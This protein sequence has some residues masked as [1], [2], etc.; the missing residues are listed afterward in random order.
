MATLCYRGISYGTMPVCLSVCLSV[1]SQCCIETN[2]RIEFFGVETITPSAYHPILCWKEI[3]VFSKIRT[4]ETLSQNLYVVR[5]KFCQLNC[6]YLFILIS[7][8][9]YRQKCPTPHV[10][11]R[12]VPRCYSSNNLQCHSSKQATFNEYE[13]YNMTIITGHKGRVATYICPTK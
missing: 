5:R 3:R 7:R 1:A 13:H 10:N 2:E 4:V 11:S 8:Q 12:V 6:V 9:N